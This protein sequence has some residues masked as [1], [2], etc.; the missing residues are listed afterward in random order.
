MRNRFR[1]CQMWVGVDLTV[2]WCFAQH[3]FGN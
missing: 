3:G 1:K 2:H